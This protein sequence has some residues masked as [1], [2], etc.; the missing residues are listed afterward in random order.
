[1]KLDFENCYWQERFNFQDFCVTMKQRCPHLHTLVLH[2]A[3]I[4]VSL[5]SMIDICSEILPNLKVL[6]LESEFGHELMEREYHGISK[7]EILDVSHCGNVS[8]CPLWKMPYLKKLRFTGLPMAHWFWGEETAPFL[9]QLEVLHLGQTNIGPYTLRLLQKYA[10]NLTE[11]SLCHTH[12]ND[13]DF[14]FSN[15]IFPFLK[16]ICLTECKVTC[17]GIIS[18]I[19]SH[20]LLQTIYVDEDMAKVYAKHPFVTAN[21]SKLGIVKHID[22]CDCHNILDYLHNNEYDT[23]L[24]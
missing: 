13:N 10:V 22:N 5:P 20:P 12:L 9:H 7:I 23:Y 1:M 6:I 18:L 19:Q 24:T 3:F 11:L 14:N 4:S 15:F 21:I 8:L 16:T 17:E 2:Y